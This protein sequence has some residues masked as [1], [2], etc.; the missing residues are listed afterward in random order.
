MK[1]KT[2]NKTNTNN[3]IPEYNVEKRYFKYISKINFRNN[4][5]Y[6]FNK[7]NLKYIKTY[8]NFTF[9]WWSRVRRKKKD[10]IKNKVNDH[11]KFFLVFFILNIIALF[12]I[13]YL[14]KFFIV[15]FIFLI[16]PLIFLV[17]PFLKSK[18]LA[19]I[20]DDNHHIILILKNKLKK[21]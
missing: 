19:Y 7:K 9:Y 8:T 16:L 1:L 20:F 21:R 13:D 6:V 2:K 15:Y 10:E 11:F 3:F 5:N 14:V 4:Q 18:K 12:F 17:L